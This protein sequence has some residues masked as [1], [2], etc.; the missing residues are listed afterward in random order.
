MN[1]DEL[2][3][4]MANLEKLEWDG[5]GARSLLARYWS[6]TAD[7]CAAQIRKAKDKQ[8]VQWCLVACDA[9]HAN[10][11]YAELAEKLGVDWAPSSLER[12]EDAIAL[13]QNLPG[14]SVQAELERAAFERA[15]VV[16]E[17]A[18][19]PDRLVKF[20]GYQQLECISNVYADKVAREVIRK[21][22]QIQKLENLLQ[23][24]IE[25][26]KATLCN[27]P[28]PRWWEAL[29]AR[30]TWSREEREM[31]DR[32]NQL[33]RRLEKVLAFADRKDWLLP[34]M[35]EAKVRLANPELTASRDWIEHE[36]RVAD[37]ERIVASSHIQAN[38]Q[39]Q[40]LTR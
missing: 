8:D 4:F 1:M 30:L 19:K 21:E 11:D 39:G 22:K 26:Q 33:T 27:H 3:P 2:R 12:L 32:L 15:A 34:R 6:D 31:G 24:A 20:S 36:R 13:R 18:Q 5:E 29:T 38:E 28:G 40:A 23:E 10:A 14:M 7:E 17:F 16:E 25:K 37:V 9:V 35:A